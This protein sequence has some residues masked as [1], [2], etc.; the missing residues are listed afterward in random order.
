MTTLL[1]ESDSLSEL[2]TDKIQPTYEEIKVINS[3]FKE[4]PKTEEVQTK[5][6]EVQVSKEQE[7]IVEELLVK[8]LPVLSDNTSYVK[9]IVEYAFLAFLIMMVY[10]V[11]PSETLKK[12]MPGSFGDNDFLELF[13]KAILV[14]VLFYIFKSYIKF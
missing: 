1:H 3:L 14:S 11:V 10:T 8:N 2:P 5:A 12:F 9:I 4:P 7:P 6:P 13:I